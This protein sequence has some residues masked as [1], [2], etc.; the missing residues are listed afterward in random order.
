MIKKVGN[1][2]ILYNSSGNKKLGTYP[3]KKE[4]LKR[5]KQI[6]YFKNKRKEK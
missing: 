2:W 6:Q 3:T 1:N 5:E 4:A